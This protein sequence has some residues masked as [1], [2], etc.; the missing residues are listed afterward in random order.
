LV[1]QVPLG[2]RPKPD[3]GRNL[4]SSGQRKDRD[5]NPVLE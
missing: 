1:A 5:V 2:Q 3:R 4:V